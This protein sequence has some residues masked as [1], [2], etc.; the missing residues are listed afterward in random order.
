VEPE[1]QGINAEMTGN[2]P[3]S[4]AGYDY[5]A[6]A[7]IYPDDLLKLFQESVDTS[8]PRS[9]TP[10]WSDISSSLQNTW[11]P[12]AT[13]NQDTPPESQDFTQQILEGGR[14]L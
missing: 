13:V 6:L 14:L 7:D 4:T 10:Y 8:A 2:M 3:A 12:P 5:P 11:H 9:V 1:Q